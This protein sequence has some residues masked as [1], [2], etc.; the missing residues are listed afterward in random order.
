MKPWIDD[1]EKKQIIE[2]IESTYLKE[3]HKTEEF[4][5]KFKEL[6]GARHA[7]SYCNGTMS[8]FAA[9]KLLGI[10][11]ND[12]VIVPDITFIASS[13]SVILTGAK[14]VF[15]D[16]D[17][18]S[19]QIDADEIEKSITPKTKAIM[20]VHLYGYSCDMD[21]I[22]S[23]AKKHN[24]KIVEDA[25]QGVGVKFNGRHVGTFGEYGSF[26][27]FGNKNI[28][29]GEGGMLI[30][31]EDELARK[32]YSFKNHGRK[33]TGTFIHEEIGYNFCITEMQ[34]AI[35]LAQ[36]AKL[37]EIKKNK[38]RILEYYK[39]NLSGIK[40]LEV[41]SGDPRCDSIPWFVNIIVP[42]ALKLQEHLEKNG[43][44]T[45]R[46]FYPLHM[47]PCYSYL[48]IPKEKFPNSLF[49]YE[50]VLSLPS[51][52]KITEQELKEVVAKIH[53]FYN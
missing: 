13:N 51:Y 9:L 3:K 1:E 14:P 53:A 34:A 28:T 16:V 44:M 42:D 29:L 50:H 17:K 19:F 27:F 4:E 21:K 6:S 52:A 32:A 23:I 26:S 43:I 39:K 38:L 18:K 40:E 47:Q 22:T 41:Y 25:A 11:E 5:S 31:N 20:P 8:L 36:L 7:I 33:K 49:L 10:K 37:E 48:K 45:R 24:L 2:V 15:V 46:I 35:G 30:T 12:E